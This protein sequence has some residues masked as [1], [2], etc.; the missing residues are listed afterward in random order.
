MFDSFVGHYVREL[1]RHVPMTAGRKARFE[2]MRFHNLNVVAAELKTTFDIDVLAGLDSDDIEFAARMFHRRHVYEHN[3]GEADE[4]YIRE[5]G[6]TSVRP[7]QA[8]RETQ[9]SAHRVAGLVAKIACNLHRGFHE[10]LEPI[11][12]PIGH[13]TERL[14]REQ[15][16]APGSMK[17][18]R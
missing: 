15:A 5:S 16:H 17:Q 18:K 13:H 3:G 2:R 4:K 6:D 11:A 7:K 1:V 9:E 12:A 14:Q 8:L 10:I